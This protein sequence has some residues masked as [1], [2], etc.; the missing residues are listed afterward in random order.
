MGGQRADGASY[1]AH[2]GAPYCTRASFACQRAPM[3]ADVV[4]MARRG[5]PA[6]ERVAPERVARE[7]RSGR[8]FLHKRA[9]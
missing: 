7:R 4:A 9:G 5:A 6:S 1:C 2:G 8:E 3:T